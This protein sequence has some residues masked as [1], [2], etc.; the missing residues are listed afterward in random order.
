MFDSWYALG[1]LTPNTCPMLVTWAA[2]AYPLI[3]M[4]VAL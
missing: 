4:P 1:C 2:H 3:V